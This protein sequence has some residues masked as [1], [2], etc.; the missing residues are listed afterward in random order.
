MDICIRQ[1]F[2]L[3]NLQI[4]QLKIYKEWFKVTLVHRHDLMKQLQNIRGANN[5]IFLDAFSHL[6]KWVCPCVGPSVGQSVTHELKTCLFAV[7]DQNWGLTTTTTITTDSQDQQ[8]LT[9]NKNNNNWL[10]TMIA[11]TDSQQQLTQQQQHQQTLNN[12]INN[13]YNNNLYN[14]NINNN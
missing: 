4:L 7:F 11:T 2:L 12:N 6:Y 9:H 1:Q 8:Q 5:K 10:T 14:N 3:N 13:L